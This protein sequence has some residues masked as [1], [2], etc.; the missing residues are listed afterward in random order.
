MP[1]ISRLA[2]LALFVAVFLGLT[3]V[4][5]DNPGYSEDEVAFV[6]V[7]LRTLGQCDVDAAVAHAWGCFPLLQTEGVG[8]V[9]AWLHAPIFAAF[10]INVWTVRLPSVLIAALALA[11]LWSFARRELGGAWTILLMVLLVTDPVLTAHAR[12]DLGPQM[13]AALMRVTA[14][15]ALWRWL[16]TGRIHWLALTC[17]AMV[18][19]FLDKQSF[20]GVIAALVGAAALVAGRLFYERLRDGAPWQPVIAGVTGALL[21]WG[22]LALA[23]EAATAD[24]IGQA[25]GRGIGAR[26][27][28]LWH[29]YAMTFSGTSV[30]NRVFGTK[31]VTTAFFDVLALV[32][33][34]TA[35]ALLAS[36]RPWTP[37]RRFLAYLTAILVLLV[38]AIAVTPREGGSSANLLFMV[39]PLPTLHLVTLLA[40]VAQHA[41]G[42]TDGRGPALRRNVAVVGAVVCGAL[43]AW[44]VSW[45]LRYLDAWR[46]NHDYRSPFDPAI[47]ELDTRINALGV[48]RVIAVDRGLYPQLVTL[49]DRA[50]A[51]RLRDWTR[52][53]LDAPDPDHAPLR[54]AVAGQLPGRRVAFVLHD[55]PYAVLAGARD[56]LEALLRRDRPCALTDG[57]DPEPRRPAALRDRRRRLP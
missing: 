53:L 16:Q 18:V 40:I 2:V 13:I 17:A 32:Q 41:G 39:W 10:G 4:G 47:A 12:L 1:A 54:A 35:A 46:N 42:A 51:A 43:F 22:A 7:A 20:G 55:P 19:G 28:G 5:L 26:L 52:H 44:N 34:V 21:I 49:D 48:D 27:A 45:Q 11:L 38:V 3:T 30:L 29:M 6:P 56:R 15:A 57:V 25:P 9:K 36:W 33:I 31:A 50:D 37:A 8:A 24:A 14:L 23:P